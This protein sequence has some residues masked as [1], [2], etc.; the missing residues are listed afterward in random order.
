MSSGVWIID[1][2]R[3]GLSREARTL[4]A[5][6][7]PRRLVYVSC[8]IATLARDLSVLGDAG[9]SIRRLDGFDFFPNTAHIELVTVLE[10]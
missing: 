5:N 9:Y 7:G 4:I 1:P 2:P 8:D 6:A 10:R 3:T